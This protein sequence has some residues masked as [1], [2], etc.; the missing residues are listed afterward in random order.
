MSSLVQQS[1]PGSSTSLQSSLSFIVS[2]AL[3]LAERTEE[4][5]LVVLGAVLMLRRDTL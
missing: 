1:Q 2:A 4:K 5:L 3:G